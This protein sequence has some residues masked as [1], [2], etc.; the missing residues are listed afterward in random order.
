MGQ[1]GDKRGEEGEFGFLPAF[2]GSAAA[3]AGIAG[4]WLGLRMRNAQ[5]KVGL[6]G[7]SS[8]RV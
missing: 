2:R 7:S 4:R 1:G 8:G 3:A 6:L 5:L